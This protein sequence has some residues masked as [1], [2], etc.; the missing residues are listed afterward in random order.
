MPDL[1]D[2]NAEFIWNAARMTTRAIGRGT[3]FTMPAA[4]GYLRVH[5]Y[6]A[7]G[8]TVAITNP[9]YVQTR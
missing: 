8:S 5:V 3:T 1:A 2:G 7:D 6:A 4:T 9:V